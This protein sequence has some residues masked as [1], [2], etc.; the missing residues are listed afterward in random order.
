MLYL[1]LAL[2][3]GQPAAEKQRQSCTK[4]RSPRRTTLLPC[5]QLPDTDLPVS[6]G[7]KEHDCLQHLD[8]GT[9]WAVSL[10]SSGPVRGLDEGHLMQSQDDCTWA[11]DVGCLGGYCMSNLGDRTTTAMSMLSI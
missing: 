4:M 10:Q 9:V 8:A 3:V 2:F 11:M 1:E 6:A 7:L 5:R